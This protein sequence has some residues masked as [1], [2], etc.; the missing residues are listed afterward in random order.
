MG[1]FS[2]RAI[3]AAVLGAA[4][5]FSSEPDKSE[6]AAPHARDA[7]NWSESLR[8]PGVAQAGSIPIAFP[9]EV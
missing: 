8:H 9:P 1:N 4:A 2:T 6:P 5:L 3:G 7:V